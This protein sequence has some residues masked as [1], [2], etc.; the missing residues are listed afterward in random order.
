MLLF[1]LFQVLTRTDQC[2]WL[3][4]CMLKVY[5]CELYTVIEFKNRIT[6]LLLYT[7]LKLLFLL[8]TDYAGRI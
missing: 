4:V 5:N 8:Y 1:E 3:T 2:Q 6:I 7:E